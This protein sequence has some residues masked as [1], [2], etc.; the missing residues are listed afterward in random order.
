MLPLTVVII[1]F[2]EE[3]NI[4]RCLKSIE[5]VAEEIIVLDSFSTDKTAEICRKFPVKFIQ[6]EWT[7]YSSAK[8]FANNIATHDYI[9]SIDADEALSDELKKSILEIKKSDNLY[10]AY[11]FNRLTNYC[12][13]WIHHCSWYPDTKLRLWNRHKGEWEGEIHEDVKM[14]N[15]TKAGFIKGDLLHFSYYSIEQH[16]K[17]L[18]N[19]TDL[20]AKAA[21]EKGKKAGCLRIFFSPC[22]KF[23][24]DYFLRLGFLDG[25]AGFV[26]CRISAHATFL[27]YAKLRQLIL[28]RNQTTDT[29]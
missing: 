9:L 16:I 18:N 6:K 21:F 2:N 19:F 22:I 3:R 20:A 28:N 24:R 7:G 15:G 12:G 29:R 17:Q 13:S 4:A 26:I 10:D 11:R 5:G 25:Y 23:I 27:K 8:N 14:K 1:T